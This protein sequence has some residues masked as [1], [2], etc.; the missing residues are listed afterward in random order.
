MEFIYE[1]EYN[2][3]LVYWEYLYL[4]ELGKKIIIKNNPGI[5]LHI[6]NKIPENVRLKYKTELLTKSLVRF[7]D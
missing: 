6:Y 3:F 5:P 2:F 7:N 1:Q 4:Y